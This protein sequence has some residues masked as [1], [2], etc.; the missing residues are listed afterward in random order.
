MKTII[1]CLAASIFVFFSGYSA[2]KK[3]QRVLV[4]TKN[5]SGYVHDNIPAAVACFQELGKLHQ[6]QVDVSDDPAV[7]TEANLAQYQALIFTSTNNDVF[8]SDAQRLAFRH[9]VE[10]GG[11]FVGVHS[12]TGTERKWSWFKMMV[13]ET[14]SWHAK[15]QPFRILNIHAAHPSMQGVPMRWEKEDE[16][17]FGKELYPGIQVL[18]MHDLS[19]LDVKQADLIN[20]YSGSFKGYFPAVWTQHF[21]GGHVWVTTLGHDK[22]NYQEPVYMNHVWQGLKYVLDSVKKIDYSKAKSVRYDEGIFVQ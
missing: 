12:V 4:Y 7:F 8:A 18:M 19:S 17:Y 14:F 9:Y 20:Q 15:F 22:A 1:L 5:G 2:P 6:I 13:G 11:G 16:C 21:Q 3:G 10:A